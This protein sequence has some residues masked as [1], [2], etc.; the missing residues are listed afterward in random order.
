[1]ICN[2]LK[3]LFLGRWSKYDVK[4]FIRFQTIVRRVT[5]DDETD[6][7]KVVREKVYLD[8]VVFNFF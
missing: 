8:F 3:A 1:M 7:F 6:Q 2:K 4:K 5:F